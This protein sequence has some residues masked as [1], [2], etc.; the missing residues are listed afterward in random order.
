VKWLNIGTAKIG[1]YSP[2]SA[3]F[4]ELKSEADY[5]E[6]WIDYLVSHHP[7]PVYHWVP[8]SRRTVYYTPSVED[9]HQDIEREFLKLEYCKVCDDTSPHKSWGGAQCLYCQDEISIFNEG[10]EDELLNKLEQF[11]EVIL[12]A[13]AGDADSMAKIANLP[14]ALAVIG[15]RGYGNERRRR[16][17]VIGAHLP[18]GRAIYR[19][20]LA[21]IY[22]RVTYL[23]SESKIDCAKLAESVYLRYPSLAEVSLMVWRQNVAMALATCYQKGFLNKLRKGVYTVANS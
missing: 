5:A 20:A 16:E 11:D 19:T 23:P 7:W 18:V 3:W 12:G 14:F 13:I 8:G 2:W 4:V 17:S 10:P 6:T 9:I 15:A 21:L 1:W 22:S